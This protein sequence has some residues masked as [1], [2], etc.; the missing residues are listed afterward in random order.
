M[1][2]KQKKPTEN[3]KPVTY[4]DVFKRVYDFMIYN[5][6]Y[7]P[8]KVEREDK[9][10]S[11]CLDDDGNE[12]KTW[13]NVKAFV[14]GDPEEASI[15]E[16]VAGLDDIYDKLASRW[17]AEFCDSCRI[18]GNVKVKDTSPTGIMKALDEAEL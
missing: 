16:E 5:T 6:G 4:M 17:D 12:H 7:A 10:V 15:F 18:L 1:N 11:I 8:N 2:K 14:G 3:K 13:S 9:R